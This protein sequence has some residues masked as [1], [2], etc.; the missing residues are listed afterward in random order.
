MCLEIITWKGG[1]KF[2]MEE[3]ERTSALFVV[4]VVVYLKIIKQGLISVL[5]HLV[6]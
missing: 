4:W 3:I 5:K 2:D 1:V 6:L